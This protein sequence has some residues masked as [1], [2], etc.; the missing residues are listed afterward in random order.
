MEF[1]ESVLLETLLGKGINS[2]FRISELFAGI[3]LPFFKTSILWSPVV[4][5]SRPLRVVNL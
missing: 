5:I 1:G 2:P 4:V 3:T